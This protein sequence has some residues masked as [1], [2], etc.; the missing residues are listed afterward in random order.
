MVRT[1]H[2]SH[3]WLAIATACLMPDSTAAENSSVVT[4]CSDEAGPAKE[5]ETTF[6]Q[7]QLMVRSADNIMSNDKKEGATGR[8]RERYEIPTNITWVHVPRTGASFAYTLL[9]LNP[10]F[11]MSGSDLIP[12]D[13]DLGAVHVED[14]RRQCPHIILSSAC[15][16]DLIFDL[17]AEGYIGDLNVSSRQLVGF[18]RQPEVRLVSDWNIVLDQRGGVVDAYEDGEQFA[19]SNQGC[20]VKI[21]TRPAKNSPFLKAK[22][23]GSFADMQEQD[24]RVHCD[25]GLEPTWAEVDQ[26]VFRLRNDYAF[27]GMTDAWDLSICLFNAMFGN[28]CH[29]DQFSSYTGHTASSNS[30]DADVSML[31]GWTDPYD[32]ILWGVAQQ[33]F[34]ENL[35]R[36][37]VSEENCQPCN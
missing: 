21:L 13:G 28:Q 12:A 2:V 18:F 32:A 20:T 19:R 23:D 16:E 15:Q 11:C 24:D 14:V 9:Q 29:A 3:L 35:Q 7:Q 33:I 30:S 22:S 5:Q 37:N 10:P 6:L 17:C 27:I 1:L 25:D 26:S 36:F 4:A 34:Q 8:G 31:N